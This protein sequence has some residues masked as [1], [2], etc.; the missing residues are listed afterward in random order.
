MQVLDLTI[1]NVSLPTIAGN[2]SVSAQQSTWVITS[3]AVSNGIALPL[4]GWLTRRFGEVR[5]FVMATLLFSLASFLCGIAQSM[6]MLVAFRAL[7]GAVAG[8]MYP[9]TQALLISVYPAHKRGQALALLAMVTVVAPIVGPILGGWITDNYSWP[10]IFFINIPVCVV[11]LVMVSRF[12][13]E[14]EDVRVAMHAMAERQRKNLDYAGI[15]MLIIGLGT[16]QYVLEE[17]NRNDW[18]QSKEIQIIT[19]VAAVSLIMLI[20][21]E[22]SATV[23]AVDF[24]LFKDMAFAS[25]TL[26]GA[27]MFAMLMTVTFLLP[28]YM[29]TMLG[30]SATQA[31][32][33]LM[34]RSL[35]MLLV[36]PI[37]GRIYNRVDPR[38][39]VAFGIILFAYSAYLMGHYTLATT[40]RGVMNVLM[41]QG[42]AFS[43]LFIPLTTMALA[44]IPRHR[45]PDATGL[46]SLL[47]QTGGSIGLAAFATMLSRF[48]IRAH[49]SMIDSVSTSRP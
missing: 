43:C 38:I 20:I 14:P 28:L 40:A 21:R 3:F 37:I 10:W 15:A 17:G 1:A 45:M 48:A 46:N 19:L 27:V 44:S 29:Q 41:I 33:A 35:V 8:P 9:I 30:F 22:L 12:V 32:I 47:R 11:S 6:G 7:Q 39:V 31:G 49:G 26:I 18:F 4:T 5:L 13:H 36:M 23:P 2:L 24:S 16:M 25:G 42:V 34:P